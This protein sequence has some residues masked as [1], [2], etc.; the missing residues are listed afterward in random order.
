MDATPKLN[1]FHKTKK[2]EPEFPVSGHTNLPEL[3]KNRLSSLIPF[4]TQQEI[5]LSAIQNTSNRLEADIFNKRVREY[6]AVQ[7]YQFRFDFYLSYCD[8]HCLV[9]ALPQLCWLAFEISKLY[10]K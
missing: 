2:L 3:P 9:N 10:L 7:K 1:K 4:L 8:E 6:S 5:L